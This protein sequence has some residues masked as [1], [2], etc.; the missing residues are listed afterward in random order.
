MVVALLVMPSAA[1]AQATPAL[2]SGTIPLS[3]FGEE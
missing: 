3:Y 1:M 2:T